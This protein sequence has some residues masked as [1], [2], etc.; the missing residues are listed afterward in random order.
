MSTKVSLANHE[1]RVVV[2]DKKKIQAYEIYYLR[3]VQWSWV[4]NKHFPE[5]KKKQCASDNKV[6][7][8]V[9]KLWRQHSIS[10]ISS[11]HFKENW[12]FCSIEISD[13]YGRSW[14]P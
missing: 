10:D 8:K 7:K 3:W 11:D 6:I 12:R 14:E 5:F 1:G 2:V 9:K 4:K 13:G